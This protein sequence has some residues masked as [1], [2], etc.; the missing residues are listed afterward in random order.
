LLGLGVALI[1]PAFSEGRFDFPLV[2]RIA[3]IPSLMLVCVSAA[4]LLFLRRDGTRNRWLMLLLVFLAASSDV[5]GRKAIA[6]PY[7]VGV[8]A[9]AAM[10]FRERP[11]ALVVAIAALTAGLL[12][13]YL[14]LEQESARRVLV[15]AAMTAATAIGLAFF[16]TR[17]RVGHAAVLAAALA[18]VAVIGVA[19][20]PRSG[21]DFPRW[22][23][24]ENWLA[25]QAWARQNTP[26]DT[27]FY[28]PDRFAF[29]TMS[30]RP[31]WWDANEGAAVMWQPSFHEEWNSRRIRARAAHTVA[32]LVGL[33]R[34]EGIRFLVLDRERCES[35]PTS[36]LVVRYSNQDYCIGEIGPS[37]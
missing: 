28:A 27:V 6:L 7:A 26:P 23:K 29:A 22:Q 34:A 2:T 8:T 36:G 16:G 25:V 20:T 13:A 1:V 3:R 33:A 14:L 37:G 17:I 19:Q 9:M 31:V 4:A 30:R 24:D 21:F 11:R 35:E 10:L 5:I 12:M 15:T 32:D 18:L